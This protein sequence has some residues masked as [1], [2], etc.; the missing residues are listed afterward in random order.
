MSTSVA[1]LNFGRADAAAGDSDRPPTLKD[2][3][4]ATP[5]APFIAPDSATDIDAGAHLGTLGP[6]RAAAPPEPVL[7]AGEAI[8]GERVSEQ[9][10][11]I[12]DAA[13]LADRDSDRADARCPDF[14]RASQAYDRP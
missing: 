7:R 1:N 5:D 4:G 13:W 12:V 8:F 14:R 11:V 6:D 3:G 9:D 2:S 10:G